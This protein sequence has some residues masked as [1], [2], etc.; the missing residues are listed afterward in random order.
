LIRGTPEPPPGISRATVRV[1]VPD[2]C[3]AESLWDYSISSR[4][5][6]L[7][8]D[9]AHIPPNTAPGREGRPP[10]SRPPARANGSVARTDR[11]GELVA[12]ARAHKRQP[13]AAA[14]SGQPVSILPRDFRTFY[15]SDPSRKSVDN[16]NNV[17]VTVRRAPIGE[18]LGTVVM[19]EY[20]GR[21]TRKWNE[22]G[23]AKQSISVGTY[24]IITGVYTWYNVGT[25]ITC[26][27]GI[28]IILK[29]NDQYD[30]LTNPIDPYGWY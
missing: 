27:P 1:S 10:P 21:F 18:V 4:W 26:S 14:V 9:R 16:V 30:G 19:V 7:N 29:A 12:A 20:T 5:V 23:R 6:P 2:V 11:V 28:Y 24:P 15:A 25:Y 8:A 17:V 13:T 3:H 22:T